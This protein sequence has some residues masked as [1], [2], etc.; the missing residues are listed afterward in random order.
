ME[1]EENI[2]VNPYEDYE[3][4]DH[5][6]TAHDHFYVV[7]PKQDPNNEMTQILCTGCPSGCSITDEFTLKNGKIV[8]K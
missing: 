7:D 6:N 2:E 3:V 8:K 5:S 4:K 1:K